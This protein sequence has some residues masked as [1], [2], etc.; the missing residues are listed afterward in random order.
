MACSYYNHQS[1]SYYNHHSFSNYYNHGSSNYYN[2]HSTSNYYHHSSTPTTTS[3]NPVYSVSVQ[4]N[5]ENFTVALAD[6]GSPE[7]QELQQRLISACE[8]I[9]RPRFPDRFVGCTVLGFSATTTRQ[10]GVTANLGIVFN[11]T[12]SAGNLPTNNAVSNALVEAASNPNN[13]FNVSFIP[14]SVT[15]IS[16]PV[17]NTTTT[18]APT[19]VAPTTAAPTTVAPT[20]TAVVNRNVTFRSVQSTFTN[21]LLNSSSTAFQNRTALIKGQIDPL[22]QSAFPSSFQSSTVVAF[23]NGSVINE[24]SIAFTSANAPNASEV[25]QV[26]INASSTVTGFD[27]EQSSVTVDGTT[28][29][30]SGVRTKISLITAF[31]L[32]LMSGLLS[33]Q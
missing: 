19:T 20:T 21:D 14:S 25:G 11:G 6:P 3:S 16:S 31:C 30:S 9:Y 15:I 29:T 18:V 22:L 32:V 28:I 5:N 24:M 7:F 1:C 2:H 26:F 33:S 8:A 17:T 27:I 23:R 13:T 4:L 12:A 10:E